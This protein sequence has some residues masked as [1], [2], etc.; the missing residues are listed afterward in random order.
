ME[1]DLWRKG[2]LWVFA[3]LY[4]DSTSEH[5]ATHCNTLQHTATHCNILQHTATA[6]HCNTL[7]HTTTQCNI[8]QHTATHCSVSQS[9]SL[10]TPL[11]KNILKI[12]LY[13]HKSSVQPFYIISIPNLAMYYAS[14][15]PA[16]YMSQIGSV[17][18]NLSKG[19]KQKA[20][21]GCCVALQSGISRKGENKAWECALAVK[22]HW[23]IHKSKSGYVL[24]LVVATYSLFEEPYIP[25]QKSPI[26]PVKQ[27]KFG[28]RLT[29]NQMYL[30]QVHLTKYEILSKAINWRARPGY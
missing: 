25:H 11:A 18:D 21:A 24:T 23:K 15:Q 7:Q 29:R 9:T 3:T 13:S 26:F 2:I 16:Q 10:Y 14:L 8:L 30:P 1:N 20:H 17:L 6:T 12:H 28:G 19:E 22:L 4:R 5:T 27:I